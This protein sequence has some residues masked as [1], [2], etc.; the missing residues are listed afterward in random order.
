MPQQQRPIRSG[1]AELHERGF[2]DFVI[3][4]AERERWHTFLSQARYRVKAREMLDRMKGLDFRRMHRVTPA[5]ADVEFASTLSELE[6][7]GAP[8]EAFAISVLEELDGRF[9]PLADGLCRIHGQQAA[10]FL[11]CIPGRLGYLEVEG[12]NE[13]YIFENLPSTGI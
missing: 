13:R 6:R 2:L 3:E 9:V 11:S 5:R 7:R 8:I 4:R 1:T 12:Q 10:T